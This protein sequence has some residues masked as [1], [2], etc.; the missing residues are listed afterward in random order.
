MKTVDIFG[1]TTTRKKAR[2]IARKLYEAE[3]GHKILRGQNKAPLRYVERERYDDDGFGKTRY[4]FLTGTGYTDEDLQELFDEMRIR[5]RYAAY[6]CTGDPF[7]I[8]ITWHRNPSGLISYV[9][10]IGYDF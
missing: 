10:R 6:D 5:P 9:H 8:Y 1:I 4:G 3:R 7:T 2:K